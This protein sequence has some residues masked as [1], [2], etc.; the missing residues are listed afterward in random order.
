MENIKVKRN[1]RDNFFCI[2]KKNKYKQ[3]N[4]FFFFFPILM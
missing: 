1:L 4:I 3:T 2:K